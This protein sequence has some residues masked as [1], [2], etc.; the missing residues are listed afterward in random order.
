ME[1]KPQQL[2]SA[3]K[4]TAS[5]HQD[6]SKPEKK[7]QK[8]QGDD[9]ISIMTQAVEDWVGKVVNWIDSNVETISKESAYA[10]TVS[11]PFWDAA[12][13]H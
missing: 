3:R 12:S 7:H 4:W 2:M 5:A 8:N 1:K 13:L 10:V 11:I 9:K 6:N